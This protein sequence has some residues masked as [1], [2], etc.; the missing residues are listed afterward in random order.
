LPKEIATGPAEI[1]VIIQSQGNPPANKLTI[2]ELGWSQEQAVAIRTKLASFVEDWDDPRMD[3][4]NG[5]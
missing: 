3:V 4:Y 5:L 2:K 1:L